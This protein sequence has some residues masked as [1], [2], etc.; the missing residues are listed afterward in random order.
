[1]RTARQPNIAPILALVVLVLT[2]CACGN[3]LGRQTASDGLT[4]ASAKVKQA[5]IEASDAKTH[6]AMLTTE[7]DCLESRV[8]TMAS[9]IESLTAALKAV[10]ED[11]ESLKR[12]VAKP[13]PATKPAP[14]VNK[15]GAEQWR[16]LVAKHFPASAVDEA[17]YIIQRESTGNPS[18]RNGSCYGLFQL[19]SVHFK[20]HPK[21]D[22]KSA[23]G[24][25]IIAAKLWR[26]SGGSFERHWYRHTS[27]ARFR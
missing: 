18:A 2:A 15:R 24:N 19:S 21:V 20:A 16:G 8:A 9:E 13:K 6:A 23:E 3:V 11:N 17:L 10:E 1:M 27:Y 26:A 22:G 7:R 4:A 5:R 14:S 25:I 12:E